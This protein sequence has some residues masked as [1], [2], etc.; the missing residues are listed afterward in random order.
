MTSSESK[1]CPK[2]ETCNLNIFQ[3]INYFLNLTGLWTEFLR[4]AI[5]YINK[6]C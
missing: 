3:N 5:L 1:L 4:V 6:F 2:F